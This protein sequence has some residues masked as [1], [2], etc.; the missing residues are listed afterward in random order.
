[1]NN[2]ITTGCGTGGD[3][4]CTPD[5]TTDY[6][7]RDQMAAFLVRGT[8]V[9]AGQSPLTY[10]CT[11]LGVGVAGA[12]VPCTN[13]TPYFLDV[14]TANPYFTYIQ[15]LYELGITTGCG[16]SG[17]YE[18]PSDDNVTRDQMAA[19]IIRALYGG[20]NGTYTCNG[21]VAGAS[22][23]C[24]TTT[25]YFSD[26]TPATEGNLFPYIQKL[27]ELGITI[28]CNNGQSPLLYCP[29]SDVTRD[30]MAAFLARSI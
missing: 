17:D 30:E 10:T 21:G 15:K 27:Y 8:Q 26:A 19:F 12:S 7:T 20:I 3:Y 23:N 6:V 25:P 4:E 16:S 13:T 5:A 29:S 11:G 9:E 18:C 1:Y 24:A 14:S 2:S 22:V 28:G